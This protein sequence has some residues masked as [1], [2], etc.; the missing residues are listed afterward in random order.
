[1]FPY[2]SAL[3]WKESFLLNVHP[4]LNFHSNETSW[5]G[6]P[7][8]K[9]YSYVPPHTVGFLRC[10]GLKGGIHFAH[11]GLESGMVF[12][13]TTR[14]E[15][16][17]SREKC[18]ISVSLV[19]HREN[20]KE[21]RSWTQKPVL[22][23]FSFLLCVHFYILQPLGS[24][25]HEIKV[26]ELPEWDWARSDGTKAANWGSLKG[27]LCECFFFAVILPT[28]K[29]ALWKE[30]TIKDPVDDLELFDDKRRKSARI[31]WFLSSPWSGFRQ[32]G[33]AC[34]SDDLSSN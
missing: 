33:T 24:G 14:V 25:Y 10:F 16:L 26:N 27:Y 13:G 20:N 12:G 1:M 31:I 3:K 29:H 6:T 17:V 11:F 22:R 23:P 21:G 9:L 19:C 2:S 4:V 28:C 32:W 18:H 7:L 8:Y 5:G 34:K 30:S 15:R